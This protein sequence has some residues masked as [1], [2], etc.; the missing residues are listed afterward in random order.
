MCS[1][2]QQCRVQCSEKKAF[3]LTKY[4]SHRLMR[5]CC[6][7]HGVT[8]AQHQGGINEAKMFAIGPVDLPIASQV[9]RSVMKELHVERNVTSSTTTV[10]QSG[11]HGILRLIGPNLCP[12]EC[13]R[14][15]LLCR[16]FASA[17]ILQPTK[18]RLVALHACLITPL[19]VVQA[20]PDLMRL[21]A[22]VASA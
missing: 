20:V 14:P 9:A 1:E 7:R 11:V 19:L 15:A 12:R 8:Y 17:S 18:V 10:S 4:T 21:K 2:L 22:L 6:P 3:C 13:S 16:S 5:L